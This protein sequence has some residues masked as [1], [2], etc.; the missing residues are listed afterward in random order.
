MGGTLAAVNGR[1]M[2]GIAAV[3][4]RR[5]DGIAAVNGRRTEMRYEDG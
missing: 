2:D 3:N 4:G 1:R 5:M